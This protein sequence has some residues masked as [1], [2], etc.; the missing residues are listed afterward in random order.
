MSTS[1]PVD[2]GANAQTEAKADANVGVQ[3]LIDRLKSEG[4]QEGQQ[5]AEALLAEAK[6]QAAKIIDAARA[7]ADTIASDAQLQAERTQ[8]NGKR[9]LELAS[10]DASLHLKEQLQHEFRGWVGGLVREQ[11]E[12]TEFVAELIREMAAQAVATLEPGAAG[13]KSG[14]KSGETAKLKLLVSPDGEKA[15]EA[16]VK[17]QAAQMLRQGVELQADRSLTHGFR[18]RIVDEDIEINFSDE[19]VT[20]ALMRF[21]APKFR[22]RISSLATEA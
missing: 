22:Q 15:I 20:A 5:Q 4:V 12:D 9:A 10:R 11:F 13:E 16:F 6:K 7:E 21:L 3:E 18:I 2:T 8:T 1:S 17:G 14:D 19:A